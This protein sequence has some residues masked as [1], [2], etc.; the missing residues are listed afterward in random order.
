MNP[1][2][3]LL[4]LYDRVADAPDAVPRLRRFVLDL[5]IRGKLVERDPADEPA[6]KLLKRIAAEK[7]RFVTTGTIKIRRY[8]SNG[9]AIDPP[10]TVPETWC[11]CRLDTVGCIVGGG[12]PSA[13][14]PTNFAEPGEGTPWLTPADLGGYKDRYIKRGARDLTNKGLQSSSATMMPAETVL[15][16]S[17]APIGY[18]AIAA[19]PM[20]TNQGFKSIVPYMVDCSNFIAL[21][22]RAFAPGIDANASGTTFGEVSGKIMAGVYF[23]L[24]P[25]AEQRRIVA[26]T[27]ELMALCDR[28]EAAR[29]AREETRHRLTKASH[30]RLS[31]PD[32]D[33]ETFRAD[34][35]FA[36]EALPA[37][38]NRVEQV[39]QLR[40]S[41]LDLAV[42]GRLVEQ[43]PADEPVPAYLEPKKELLKHQS[44]R[45]INWRS[46]T[47]GQALDFRYGKTL[48][49][50]KRLHQGPIPVFGSNGVVGFTDKPLTQH[51]SIIIGR[52]GSAGALNYC[53]SPSWTT[54]V[55]YFVEVPSF[56]ILQYLYTALKTLNLE[57]LAKGVKPGISRS[58]AYQLRILIPPLAEQHRIVAKVDELMALCDRLEAHLN[59]AGNDR[60]CLLESLLRDA[61]NPDNETRTAQR[62]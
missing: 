7:A 50:S 26:K 27:D 54:D 11:W 61:L 62:E 35:R 41:I 43:D 2:E 36:V 60:Q 56:L 40:R 38:T 53:D 51:P 22:M 3:R 39:K 31:A 29:T 48:K 28:L 58:D 55:A 23:P 19:N 46:T 33:D 15:F 42:R 52:K 10:F 18:V 30:A 24:P 9:D 5:A 47:V 57:Q 44:A 12:T 25:L 4:A 59:A 34:A 8:P 45:P 21:V 13:A 6:S 20:A 14:D 17:R 16:T 37:L 1:A 49:A 32:A